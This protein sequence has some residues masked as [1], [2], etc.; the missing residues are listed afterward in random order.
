MAIVIV[1]IMLFHFEYTWRKI[2]LSSQSKTAISGADESVMN[3]IGEI[4]NHK[5][6]G[7]GEA[8]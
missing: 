5:M 3:L 8:I 6:S 4:V 7:M 2:H 1:V